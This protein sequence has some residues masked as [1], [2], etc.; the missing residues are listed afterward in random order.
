MDKDYV[1]IGQIIKSLEGDD[2]ITR[3]GLYYYEELGLIAP[4]IK[5]ERFNLY[6][7]DTIDKVKKIRELSK[8]YKLEAIVKMVKEGKL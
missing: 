4:A 7:R 6:T 8:S 3:Q 5:T 1:T 2:K